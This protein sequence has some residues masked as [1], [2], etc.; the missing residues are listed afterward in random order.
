MKAVKKYIIAKAVKED[1]V[2]AGGI[3]VNSQ[4]GIPFKAQIVSIPKDLED[5]TYLKEGDTVLHDGAES[6]E[7]L[8]SPLHE[9]KYL[10]MTL[11]DI[12]A[13]L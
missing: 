9:E 5:A 11:D 1:V 2:T 4:Q 6:M 8:A 13:I 7:F 12:I 10:A 3:L